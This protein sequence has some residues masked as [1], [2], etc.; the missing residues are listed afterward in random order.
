MKALVIACLLLPCACLA[1]DA[2][3]T[4]TFALKAGHFYHLANS[5][6]ESFEITTDYPVT[7]RER[8]CLRQNVMH[9]VFH[10]SP[11]SDVYIY[12][13]RPILSIGAEPNVIEIK[14]PTPNPAPPSN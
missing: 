6:V 14:L 11:A 12:D 4:K 3:R 7:I 2:P 13:Q 10:C 8:G 1:Q 5:S 9:T